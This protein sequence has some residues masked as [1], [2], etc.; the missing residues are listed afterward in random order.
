MILV[1]ATTALLLE[2]FG[3][4]RSCCF[5][6]PDQTTASA[7]FRSSPGGLGLGAGALAAAGQ[8]EM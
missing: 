5:V 3:S 1:G 2:I 7:E 4:Q 8:Q 6:L